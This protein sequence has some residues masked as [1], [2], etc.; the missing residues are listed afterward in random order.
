MS[1]SFQ[2]G[3]GGVVMLDGS[4][5]AS[6]EAISRAI[7]LMSKL[8]L[9][10]AMLSEVVSINMALLLIIIELMLMFKTF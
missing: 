1:Y 9:A 4:M 6:I 5:L 2:V 8:V 3:V 10:A 7:L